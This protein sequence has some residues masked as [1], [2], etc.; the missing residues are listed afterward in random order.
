MTPTHQH[1]LA[2]AVRGYT[3][4]SRIILAAHVRAAT[5]HIP[6]SDVAIWLHTQHPETRPILHSTPTYRRLVS[7]ARAVGNPAWSGRG[8]T[9]R[10]LSRRV[11]VHLTQP[12]TASYGTRAAYSSARRALAIISAELLRDYADGGDA[13]DSV[14]LSHQWL[15]VRMGVTRLTARAAVQRC[16]TYHWLRVVKPVPGGGTRMRLDRVRGEAAEVRAALYA[17]LIDETTE[18]VLEGG[19]A[20]ASLAV[21]LLLRADHPAWAY[22]AETGARDRLDRTTWTVAL[23]DA[24]DLDPGLLGVTARAVSPA[25]RTL[26]RVGIAR[27]TTDLRTVLAVEADRCGATARARDAEIARRAAA[28]ARRIAVDTVRTSRASAG[29]AITA[30][31]RV[32]GPVP[33]LTADPA[34]KAG[35][36]QAMHGA[37]T[38]R[39]EYAVW[40]LQ[41]RLEAAGWDAATAA[42]VARKIV[43]D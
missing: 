12:Y 11:I 18:T 24:L 14:L 1:Q 17:D 38:V 5:L 33:P 23:A 25:R 9:L 26:E 16:V 41:R 31:V 36:S 8:E 20:T 7:A 40:V 19:E 42:R 29:R 34:A 35:W 27:G 15:A 3:T 37:L 43:G 6:P 32:A 10:Q 28:D 2:I 39:D 13:R 22:S 4:P 30:A 21:Q